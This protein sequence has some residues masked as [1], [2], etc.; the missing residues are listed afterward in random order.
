MSSLQNTVRAAFAEQFGDNPAA[1]VRAP[2]RV[3]LI[4]EH[5][6]YNAGFVMP[7]AI[8]RATWIALRPRTDGIVRIHALGR[9]F[10]AA[11]IVEFS[12][13]DLPTAPPTAEQRVKHWGEYVKGVAWALR[14]AGHSVHG[15][16]AVVDSDVPI[17]AGL[18][19]SAALE[20]AIARAFNAIGGW[21]WD[22]PTMALLGQK[23]ENQWVGVNSGIMDQ[24]ISAAGIAGRALLIDCESLTF[25]P[26]PLPPKTVVVILDTA[27]RRELTE[28]RYNERFDEA[29]AARAFFGGRMLRHVTLDELAAAESA[30]PANVFQRARHIITENARTQSAGAALERGD[31]VS[32]GALMNASHAS[33]RDDFAVTNAA[34]DTMA[35]IAQ[36]TPGCYGAR[37]TGAGFGGCAVALIDLDH[38]GSFAAAVTTAYQTQ[39]GR[40]PAVYVTEAT[41][42]AAI[43]A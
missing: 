36:A 29:K 34:L 21:E 2:G 25:T 27:T 40:A 23:A 18:S 5:T 12:P 17:G 37:M 3:N 20:L 9:E 1:I 39:T 33:L 10:A 15:F 24:M 6:D 7:L 8:N 43:V 16:D 31:A 42:G 14:G 35:A 4:G 38:A 11:P 41:D 32:M 30:L 28:S 19:S 22:A 13:A 26:A